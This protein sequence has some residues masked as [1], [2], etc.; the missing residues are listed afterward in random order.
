[1][2]LFRRFRSGLAPLAAAVFALSVPEAPSHATA[3]PPGAVAAPASLLQRLIEAPAETLRIA[4]AELDAESLRDLYRSRAFQPIWQGD[5]RRETLLAMIDGAGREGLDPGAYHLSAIKARLG[6]EGEK[7]AELELLLSDAALRYGRAMRLGRVDP[8]AAEQDWQHAR[9]GFDA[10]A[11][12]RRLAK[13]EPTAALDALAP[14]YAGY[15][16]LRAALDRYRDLRKAGGWPKVPGGEPLKPGAE[17][18]RVPAVRARL[19]ATGEFAGGDLE[20]RLFDEELTAAVQRFQARHG[21]EPD[22]VVGRGTL[23]TMNVP[24]ESRIGQIV[25]NMER[26]RWLPRSLEKRH[27]AVNI[28]SQTLEAVEDGAVSLSTRVI[29][30]KPTHKTVLFRAVMASVTLNPPWRVPASIASKEILPELKRNP[31]YLVANRLKILGF[32]PGTPESEGIGI[33]WKGYSD[34]P[35]QLRQDP[36]EDNSL[37]RIKF[38]MPNANDIYLHDTPSRNLFAKARR[39]YSHGCVRVEEPLVL[40]AHLIGKPDVT[41]A[42]LQEMIDSGGTQQVMLAKALPIYLFYFTAWVDSDGLVQ[43]R[44]DIYGYDKALGAALSRARGKGDL[45]A[46]R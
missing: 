13:D 35:Y 26:W 28:A 32:E 16:Q 43:F 18:D 41:P 5:A 31:G 9:P 34:F 6:A 1:M 19:A 10:V 14:P 42:A 23:A 8:A 17:D 2:L 22:G 33:N 20:S 21:L 25:A 4:G 46:K 36:G 11:F 7:A 37:G 30:G 40:A 27:L 45:I 38:N 24:V 12:L 15:V 39:A 29:V 44:D 3:A